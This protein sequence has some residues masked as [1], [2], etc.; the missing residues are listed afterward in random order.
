MGL[1]DIETSDSVGRS[2]PRR[3]SSIVWRRTDKSG[4]EFANLAERD[5]GA[6]LSGVAVLSER[7]APCRVRYEIDLDAQWRTVSCLLTG[8]IGNRTVE[9]SIKRDGDS[10]SVNGVEVPAIVGCE[11]I[12]LGFSPA[13][14]LLPIR[15]LA[16]KVGQSAA[17][18]A[19]W[20]HFP[21]LTVQLLEQKYSRLADDRYRYES[22]GGSFRRELKVDEKG[23]VL[24]YPDLWYAE[25][26]T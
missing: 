5:E 24:E 16:L 7:G 14:N 19:A 2:R 10:W 13:T 12:D 4:H 3:S 20:V 25:S 21:E 8:Q 26:R 23:F 18:R 15:R 1:S 6:K 11:D 22:A 17:V 9:V